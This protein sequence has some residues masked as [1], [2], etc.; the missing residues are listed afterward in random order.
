MARALT[1]ATMP[2][3]KVEGNEFVRRNGAFVMT[4]QA[5]SSIG[6]PYGSTPRLLMAWVTTEAVRTRSR[7]LDLGDSM[8]GFMRELGLTP[9]SGK[10]GQTR[11]LKQQTRRLF[12]ATVSCN[13]KGADNGPMADIGYRIASKAILWWDA[14]NPEQRSL[15]QSSVTLSGDFYDELIERPVPVDMRALKALRRS[16]LALDIYTWLTWRMSYLRAPVEIP[17]AALA[18]QFGSDY[19]LVRQF[20]AAFIAELRRVLTVYPDARVNDGE[21]GLL[22]TPSPTHVRKATKALPRAD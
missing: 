3:R 18:Q 5:P 2:H 11:M 17:W 1:Q 4:M 6:L 19:K 13:Y 16:P 12:N 20:K 9:V 7:E 14:P 10:R 15:W 22:L 21:A 8:A